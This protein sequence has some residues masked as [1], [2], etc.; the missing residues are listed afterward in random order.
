MAIAT[1]TTPIT[2]VTATVIGT[3]GV[4][5]HP[6]GVAIPT[7]T[8]TTTIGMTPTTPTTDITTIPTTPTTLHTNPQVP[9]DPVDIGT[10]K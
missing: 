9:A 2:T 5:T 10:T 3:I 4:G 7:T 1:A 6:I 8:S